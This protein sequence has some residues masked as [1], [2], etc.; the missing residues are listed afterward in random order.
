MQQRKQASRRNVAR[1]VR[2][3]RSRNKKTRRNVFIGVIVGVV[4]GVLIMSLLLPSLLTGGRASTSSAASVGDYHRSIGSPHIDVGVVPQY[5]TTPPTSGPHYDQTVPW[6]VYETEVL[7]EQVV[8]NME[9]GG[10]VIS[11]NLS[12]PDQV[13]TLRS[14]VEAQPGFP[15]CLLMRTYPAIAEGTVVLTSWEW[16][17][18]FQG[19]N[20]LQMQEFIDDHKNRGPENLGAGCDG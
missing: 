13:A 17:Q 6:G 3:Q 8:H 12:V 11:H 1:E 16:L 20:T 18:E 10:V 7:D 19:L 2:R 14:F 9:H 15:G 5:S 4:G